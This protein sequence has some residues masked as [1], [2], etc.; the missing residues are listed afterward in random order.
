MLLVSAGC[1][2]KSVS[3]VAE[4]TLPPLKLLPES[5]ANPQLPGL[6]SFA[7]IYTDTYIAKA[8]LYYVPKTYN[9]GQATAF[10]MMLHGCCTDATQSMDLMQKYSDEHNIILL[11]PVSVGR[12]WDF[13]SGKGF[14]DDN[15]YINQELDYMFK[16]FNIDK[17]KVAIA[18]FSDGASYALTLGLSRDDLFTHIMAFS[19]GYVRI[20]SPTRKPEIFIGHGVDDRVLPIDKCSRTIVKQLEAHG[21]K[22]NYTEFAGG[23]FVPNDISLAAIN[24]FKK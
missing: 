11:A 2:K 6:H 12:T 19:P 5:A 16:N 15:T 18:G 23:H 8:V 24:W 21:Y 7:Y 10:L 1:K 17:S 13:I 4:Q 22:A 3:L 14:A 20:S 9:A